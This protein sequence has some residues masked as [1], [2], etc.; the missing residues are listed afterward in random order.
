MQDN[1]NEMN[2]LLKK[3]IVFVLFF[4]KIKHRGGADDPAW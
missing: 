2:K 1:T 3:L 4:S